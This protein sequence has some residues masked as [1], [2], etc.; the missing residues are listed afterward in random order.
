MFNRFNL[1]I[2]I[3]NNKPITQFAFGNGLNADDRIFKIFDDVY[4][5]TNNDEFFALIF[6]NLLK[7]L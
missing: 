3:N 6:I 5:S 2:E 4:N 7:A 1:Y